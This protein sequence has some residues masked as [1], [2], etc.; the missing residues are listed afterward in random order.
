MLFLKIL[1]W[2]IQEILILIKCIVERVNIQLGTFLIMQQL[3]MSHSAIY[4]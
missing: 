3:Q 4:D 2:K 1:Y